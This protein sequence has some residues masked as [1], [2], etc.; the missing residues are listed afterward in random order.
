[1]ASGLS[2]AFPGDSLGCWGALGETSGM[3]KPHGIDSPR[4]IHRGGSVGIPEEADMPSSWWNQ[5]GFKEEMAF[6]LGF[7]D[8]LYSDDGEEVAEEGAMYAFWKARTSVQVVWGA[9]LWAVWRK[10]EAQ[11]QI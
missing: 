2:D 5:A 9:R 7:L 8:W 1:M 3:N 11:H 4:R 6:S 10:S